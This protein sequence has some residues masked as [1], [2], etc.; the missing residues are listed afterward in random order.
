MAAEIGLSGAV[1]DP[2]AM[3][4]ALLPEGGEAE[5]AELARTLAMVL[6]DRLA[7]WQRLG[8]VG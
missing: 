1:P 8:V 3:A 4:T 6:R 5:H 7:V 2:A